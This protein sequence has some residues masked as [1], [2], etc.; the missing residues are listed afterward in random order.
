MQTDD[1]PRLRHHAARR[2]PARGHH[3]LGGRQARGRAAARPA[4]RR[5]HRG[6]LAGRDAQGHRVLRPRR[7]RRAGAE[8]RGAGRVRCDPQGRRP[9]AGRPA[10]AGA[11]RLARVGHHPGRQ[12]RCRHVEQALRTTLEENLA[13]V[14]D[15]VA[16]LRAEGR[17][18]FLDCEHFFDGYKHD[19][20]YGVRRARRRAGGRRGRR[21]A[22][23]HQR[24]HAADGRARDRDRGAWSHRHPARH[25]HPGR[26]RLRGGQHPGRRRRRRDARPGHRQRLRRAGRQRQHL[27]RHRRPGHQD[28]AR[29][30]AR[31]L[32]G[33]DGAG[34]ARDRRDRQPGAGHARRL[35]RR[36]GVRAQGRPAR[37]GDQGRA[38]LYN[39]LDPTVVGNDQRILVTEM[40]G[41]ASVELKSRELGLDVGARPDV[42]STVVERGQG[43]RGR[44]LVL[45]GR[46]RVVRAAGARRAGRRA[47]DSSPSSPTA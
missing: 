1:V 38:E 19:P 15:T 16:F 36:V 31:R 34:L 28:G 26:H 17:R 43:A 44:G 39:H 45:R 4:R 5:L 25:P 29:R 9:C 40:A 35:R 33:R 42:V 21:R 47:D 12:V 3:L 13:M 41:R 27:L 18:V 23:R 8:E 10:G 6:R 24:R 30:A 37:V 2:R 7:R 22:V 32:P 11:A 20:D 46:R 14:R